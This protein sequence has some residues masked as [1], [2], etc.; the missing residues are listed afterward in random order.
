MRF[1]AG[2]ESSDNSKSNWWS[3]NAEILPGKTLSAGG[4]R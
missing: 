1:C 2:A 4:K 3:V